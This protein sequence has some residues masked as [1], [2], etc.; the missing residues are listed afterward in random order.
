MGQKKA[1]HVVVQ[2]LGVDRHTLSREKKAGQTGWLKA[3]AFLVRYGH[4][5]SRIKWDV[6]RHGVVSAQAAPQFRAHGLA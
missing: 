3:R 5:T 2:Y 1:L 4:D 6:A